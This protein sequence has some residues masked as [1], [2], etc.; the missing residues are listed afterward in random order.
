MVLVERI[1]VHQRLPQGDGLVQLLGTPRGQEAGQRS[2]SHVPAQPD[3]LAEY[4]DPFLVPAGQQLSPLARD[5]T[6]GGEVGPRGL[7]ADRLQD[8]V[9]VGPRGALPTQERAVGHQLLLP[10]IAE[11]LTAPVDGL[12]QRVGGGAIAGLGEE[13]PGSPLAGDGPPG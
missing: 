9:G 8:A 4:V 5:G 12:R 6:E 7:G 3:L 10:R 2:A 11:R 1:L 13:G